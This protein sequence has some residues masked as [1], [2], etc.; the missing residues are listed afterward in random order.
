[1]TYVKKYELRMCE[2]CIYLGFL[3]FWEISAAKSGLS[4]RQIFHGIDSFLYAS[5]NLN[6]EEKIELGTG[7]FGREE[8][9]RIPFFTAALKIEKNYT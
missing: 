7:G 1:M 9:A 8:K 5:G 3:K 4:Y 6:R 2:I